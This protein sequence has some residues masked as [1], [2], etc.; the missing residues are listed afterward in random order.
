[1]PIF[2]QINKA[3]VPIK[4]YTQ[5]IA[6]QAIDQLANEIGVKDVYFYDY[7][8]GLQLKSLEVYS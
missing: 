1:M 8:T 6:P 5:D 7:D 4:I 3:K 2:K